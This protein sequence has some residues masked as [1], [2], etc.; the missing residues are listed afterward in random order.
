MT[1]TAAASS[2]PPPST[3]TPS[4]SPNAA[5]VPQTGSGK[6]AKLRLDL[7]PWRYPLF[8]LRALVRR[9]LLRLAHDT[10]LTKRATDEA[11]VA[12][13]EDVPPYLAQFQHGELLKWK[14]VEFRV[15]KVVGNPSPALIIVATNATHGKLVQKIRETR[16]IQKAV[17]RHVAS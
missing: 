10:P 1:P 13:A 11:W 12:R 6:A 9:A 7:P 3:W 15:L 8:R 4:A 14:G 16:R 17:R 5:A 2:A